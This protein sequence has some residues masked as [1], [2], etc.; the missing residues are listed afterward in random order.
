M[1]RGGGG[2][3]GGDAVGRAP[4]G[5]AAGGRVGFGRF[6][7]GGGRFGG[8]G[9]AV[10]AARVGG[11]GDR[12]GAARPLLPD[13]SWVLMSGRVPGSVAILPK[14]GKDPRAAVLDSW[15]VSRELSWSSCNMG[16]KE[17]ISQD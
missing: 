13:L 1:A 11:D 16:E 12:V 2:R 6:G 5:A 8:D 4:L 9:D 7:V 10:G 17:G 14:G 15:S 3:L